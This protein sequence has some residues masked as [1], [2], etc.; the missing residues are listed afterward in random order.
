MAVG[1][2]H[3][4][5]RRFAETS[6]LSFRQLPTVVRN[7]VRDY[8]GTAAIDDIERGTV[9]GQTVYEAAFKNG[10]EPIQLRV[11]EDGSLV[12]DQPNERFIAQFG[13]ETPQAGVGHAPSWQI[14][15]GSGSSGAGQLSNPKPFAFGQLP[16]AVQTALRSQAGLGPLKTSSREHSEEG[17]S[18]RRQ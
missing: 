18:T 10:T 7:T 5:E 1:C 3:P 12:K 11:D 14:L 6:K 2:D 15:K 13:R 4:A 9:N 17:Q 16:V 8:A